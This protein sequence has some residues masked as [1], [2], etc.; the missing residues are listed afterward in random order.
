MPKI[1]AEEYFNFSLSN[2][3]LNPATNTPIT[4]TRMNS[5]GSLC[6]RSYMVEEYVSPGGPVSTKTPRPVVF[7]W[8]GNVSVPIRVEP[9]PELSES[10][11]A[12]VACGRTQKSGVT[13]DGKLIFWEVCVC[14]CILCVCVLYCGV[15]YVCVC[16]YYTLGKPFSLDPSHSTP[17]LP[18][19]P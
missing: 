12:T 3:R 9:P 1:L 18:K 5:K 10:K 7:L 4:C 15:V 8:G 17:P 2:Y 6:Q 11:M 19:K 13:D 16:C 14:M